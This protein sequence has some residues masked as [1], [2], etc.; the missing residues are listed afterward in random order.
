MNEFQER[1]FSQVQAEQQSNPLTWWWLS[2][3]D[4]DRPEGD[5]F[6]GACIVQ[7]WGVVS[8]SMEAHARKCNPG[9]QVKGV[10]FPEH[11]DASEWA[12]TVLNREQVDQFNQWMENR[13]S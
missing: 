2:F 1:V 12:H 11:V 4:P 8:A 7:G 6:V 13:Y 3:V 5:K 10:P 9:G